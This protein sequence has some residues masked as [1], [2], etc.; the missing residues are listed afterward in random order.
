MASATTTTAEFIIWGLDHAAYGPV[1]FATLLDWVK[2]ERVTADTWVFREKEERW[3]KAEEM[4]ELHEHFAGSKAA[5]SAP[6]MTG[7]PVNMKPGALRR[8]KILAD[9]NDQQLERFAIFMELEKVPQ[10][11]QIVKQ[12]DHGDS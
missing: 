7:Q 2:D 8:M 9:L 4:P 11:N 3:Q 12:G 1:E 10:W 6:A 5:H